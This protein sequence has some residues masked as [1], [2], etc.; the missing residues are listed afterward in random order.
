M[1]L[2]QVFWE[3]PLFLWAGGVVMKQLN[4]VVVL[5]RSFPACSLCHHLSR[6]H[7]YYFS[8]QFIAPKRVFY[9]G[10]Y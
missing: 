10:D 7:K 5:L 4:K 9:D 1:F 3:M 6:R 8:I 2:V